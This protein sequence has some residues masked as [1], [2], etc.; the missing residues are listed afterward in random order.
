MRD[1]IQTVIKS[2]WGLL[3]FMCI[4]ASFVQNFSYN[5]PGACS[6]F[7]DR[8]TASNFII[9]E[10]E[11]CS[12]NSKLKYREMKSFLTVKCCFLGEVI[13]WKHFENFERTCMK[14]WVSINLTTHLVFLRSLNIFARFWK[15]ILSL[16]DVLRGLNTSVN[17]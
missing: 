6:W 10:I 8:Q 12:L 1:A 17:D 2:K 4:A 11:I 14:E 15:G 16:R 5:G 9:V 3:Y 7:N 13:E